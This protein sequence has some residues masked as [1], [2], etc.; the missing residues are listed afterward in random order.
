MASFSKEP[1]GNGEFNIDL[2]IGRDRIVLL[3]KEGFQLSEKQK[4]GLTIL[5]WKN[6]M[7]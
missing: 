2:L 1:N 7:I 6:L 3:Q 4:N 5:R